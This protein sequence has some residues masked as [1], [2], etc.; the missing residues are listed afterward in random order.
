[1]ILNLDKEQIERLVKLL[2]EKIG[3]TN[4]VLENKDLHDFKKQKLSEH[5]AFDENIK[6]E[7]E[8]KL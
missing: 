2:D 5:I 3:A 7:L 1:M 4:W 8:A 6:K